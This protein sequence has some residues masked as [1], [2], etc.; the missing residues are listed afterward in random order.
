MSPAAAGQT[1]VVVI[2]LAVCCVVAAKA[3]ARRYTRIDA[4]Y[5]AEWNRTHRSR[6]SIVPA[7]THYIDDESDAQ[8]F[9]L[10]YRDERVK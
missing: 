6:L 4:E 7:T 3:I 8:P 10:D 1:L 5:V 2:T 9:A